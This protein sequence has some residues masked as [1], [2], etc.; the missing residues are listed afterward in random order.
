MIA[1]KKLISIS[2]LGKIFSRR[3][4]KIIF[5][6]NKE[7]NLFRFVLKLFMVTFIYLKLSVF[8]KHH[9]EKR[10]F[11]NKTIKTTEFEVTASL[12]M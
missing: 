3:W 8:Q 1:I 2:L 12:N 10:I 5:K 4:R 7:E 9:A 6:Q 11:N